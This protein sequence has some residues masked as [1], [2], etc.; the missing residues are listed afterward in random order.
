MADYVRPE[1]RKEAYAAI[2]KAGLSCFKKPSGEAGMT[3]VGALNYL[4]LEVATLSH[5]LED[6]NQEKR[7]V[8]RGRVVQNAITVAENPWGLPARLSALI[9][10]PNKELVVKYMTAEAARKAGDVFPELTQL[11]AGDLFIEIR[12]YLNTIPEP[13]KGD[14]IDTLIAS[15][16]SLSDFVT[17]LIFFQILEKK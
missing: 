13:E 2:A 3:L 5:L 8:V 16:P 9:P 1:K 11:H 7:Q 14:R 12:D 4:A 15:G 17:S 6:E 10:Y